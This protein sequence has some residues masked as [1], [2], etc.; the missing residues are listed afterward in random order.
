MAKPGCRSRPLA[1][2]CRGLRYST[3]SHLPTALFESPLGPRAVSFKRLR[4]F[5]FLHWSRH[6]SGSCQRRRLTSSSS[7]I[8]L[9]PSSVTLNMRSPSGKY[10]LE[11]SLHILTGPLAVRLRNTLVWLVWAHDVS[12]DW[13]HDHSEERVGF[14]HDLIRN[15]STRIE[16]PR[17]PN[18]T[19]QVA[20]EFL[21][22]SQQ[23]SLGPGTH[24]GNAQSENPL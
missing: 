20:V 2:E 22:P 8:S 4:I 18:Q 16:R 7:V 9:I 11:M 14:R 3:P 1:E 21:L 13:F 23:A 17:K 19:V 24:F 5:Q 6:G 15:H 10:G 12:S